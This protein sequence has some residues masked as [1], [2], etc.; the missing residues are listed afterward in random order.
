VA[1]A[2]RVKG[3]RELNRALKNA[4]GDLGKDLRKELKSAAEIVA[5][6]ARSKFTGISP[7]SAASMQPRVRAGG[8]VVEQRKRRTTGQHPQFGRLQMERAFIPALTEKTPEV[9]RKLEDM[10]DDIGRKNGF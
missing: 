3:L 1:G 10:I 5:E 8:A 4:E 9:V 7:E 2:I 6:D